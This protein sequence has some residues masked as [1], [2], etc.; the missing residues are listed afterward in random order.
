MS[1]EALM[2]MS[3]ELEVEACNE[4]IQVAWARDPHRLPFE[5]L[6]GTKDDN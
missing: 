5:E 4:E 1:K 6:K 2:R 3:F